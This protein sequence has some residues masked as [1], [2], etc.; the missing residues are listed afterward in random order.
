M[1]MNAL[2]RNFPGLIMRIVA[3]ECQFE[4]VAGCVRL[5]NVTDC[6]VKKRLGVVHVTRHRA[7]FAQDC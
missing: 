5:A 6:R 7:G 3:L 4:I 2:N 1:G